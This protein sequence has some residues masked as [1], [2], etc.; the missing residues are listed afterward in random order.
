[1]NHELLHKALYYPETLDMIPRRTGTRAPLTYSGSKLCMV[2]YKGNDKQFGLSQ[3]L[4]IS[5][6]ALRVQVPKYEAYTP[7]H[8]YDSQWATQLYSIFGYFEP[9]GSNCLGLFSDV[10]R[11]ILWPMRILG[12]LRSGAALREE[13]NRSLHISIC[14]I[15]T[16]TY[17][18][19]YAHKYFR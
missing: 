2:F 6:L 11:V 7:Y 18:C 8:N 3:V 10:S 14:Y 17:I 5:I 15:H 9:L 13:K 1:M 12:C 16:Y 4:L 19:I